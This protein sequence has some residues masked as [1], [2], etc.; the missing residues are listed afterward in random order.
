MQQEFDKAQSKRRK[1]FDAICNINIVRF[2]RWMLAASCWG[3]LCVFIYILHVGHELPSLSK[4]QE[5]RQGRKVTILDDIGQ[6]VITYGNI[7]GYYVPYKEIPKNLVNAVLSIEDRRF[8]KHVGVDVLGI[9]RAF[10]ANVRAGRT[11]QGGSTLTQQLAKIAFLNPKRTLKRK[12]QEALMALELERNYSKEEILSIYLNRVYLGSGIYGIDSA[13]KYYFGK[14]VQDLDLYECAIIAGLLK[15]PSKLSPLNNPELTGQRAY[16]V[17]FNML[18]EGYITKSQL[19]DAGHSIKLNTSLLGSREYGYFTSW[20][21][22]NIGNYIGGSE[23]DV[24]VKT[25]LNKRVQKITQKLLDDYLKKFGAEKKI[26][27]GAVVVMD[28]SSGKLLGVVG[29]KDFAASPFNRAT[30]ALRPAGSAFK[31]FVYTAAVERGYSPESVMEDKPIRFGSWT[32]ENYKKKYLGE[33]TLDEAFS[34]SLNTIPVQLANRIGV[35]SIIDVA[36]RMGI[37]S[38]IESNLSIALGS[39]SVSLLELTAAY[40]TIANDGL[41]INPYAVELVEN[42]RTGG[43]LYARNDAPKSRVIKKE[44]A[45]IMQ[46]ML[47]NCV[48]HGSAYAANIPQ[49]EISGKTGTSQDHRDIW[50][51]GFTDTHVIGV[52]MGNDDY[53]PMKKGVTGSSYPT[54]LARDVLLALE[55]AS[56][57]DS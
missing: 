17:L 56:V 23:V 22:D 25:T 15:A 24:S 48:L 20:V 49:L 29:G 6:P 27:Q 14:N 28:R 36:R 30:Q 38:E 32:P 57:T 39:V 41:F 19:D 9:F 35:S 31:I 40:A 52:W 10:F 44:P 5:P 43:V 37:T 21:Y 46:E 4:L 2:V 1:I 34:K 12:V 45:E 55:P 18:E 53:S 33:V 3:A 16:Q 54:L 13:A 7:Y 42:S 51:I 11:V 50:F 47:R 8:F 26:S